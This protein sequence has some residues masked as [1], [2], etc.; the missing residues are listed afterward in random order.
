[1]TRG[2]EDGHRELGRGRAACLANTHLPATRA[3]TVRFFGSSLGEFLA[4]LRTGIARF[5]RRRSTMKTRIFMPQSAHRCPAPRPRAKQRDLLRRRRL[6]EKP[7]APK[8]IYPSVPGV[9]A[10]SSRSAATTQTS[11]T[12]SCPCTT[13]PG[14]PL[15]PGCATWT[16]T[17][18]PPATI[19]I[20]L[21]SSRSARAGSPR[22]AP[23]GRKKLPAAPTPSCN[24]RATT[25]STR[26]VSSRGSSRR[27]TTRD[28]AP[29]VATH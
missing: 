14:F 17:M 1:M 29:S 4:G 5:A 13:V 24:F 3:T 2:L 6:Q 7:A 26:S 16:A 9:P 12:G 20:V 25:F 15:L 8:W 27:T 22:R 21:P 11:V 28:P 19:C 23:C 10:A 18:R